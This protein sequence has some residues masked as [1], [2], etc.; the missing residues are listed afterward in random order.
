MRRVP[1][2]SCAALVWAFAAAAAAQPLTGGTNLQQTMDLQLRLNELQARQDEAARQAAIQQNQL[3]T[4]DTQLRA[5]QALE[6]VR[7]EA[8]APGLPPPYPGAPPRHIDVE[9]LAHMPD[10]ILADSDARVRAA[11][12]SRP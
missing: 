3:T 10:A 8:A 7:G 1:F 4:L 9:Q 5:R 11:A 12:G 6:D 2:A